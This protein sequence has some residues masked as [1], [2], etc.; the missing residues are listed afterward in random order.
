MD[1]TNTIT[2]TL[3]NNTS[4]QIAL[5]AARNILATT[6]AALNKGCKHSPSESLA[7]ALTLNNNIIE[8][9][10]GFFVPEDIPTVIEIIL[11][12]IATALKNSNF[13]CTVYTD[14]TYSADEIEASFT[15][16]SLHIKNTYYPCG[17]IGALYCEECGE[18]IVSMADFDPTVTYYCPECGEEIDLREQYTEYAPVIT[19]TTKNI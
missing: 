13:S 12:E 11:T 7:N 3:N 17:Y 9:E 1:Y 5:K 14:S 6:A 10:D 4:S 18:E 16:G 15:N 19:E 8:A 2:I